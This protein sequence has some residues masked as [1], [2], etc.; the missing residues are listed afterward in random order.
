MSFDIQISK[1]ILALVAATVLV[2][3]DTAEAQY[4]G[5]NKVQYEDFDFQI[6]ETDHFD[7]YFYE[8]AE[9]AA[10]MV[11]QMAERWYARLSRLLDH[12]LRGHQPI[13]MYASHPHF[14]QTNAVGGQLSEST[15]GVTEVFKRRIVLPFAGPM[16]ETDHVL[17]H[18]IVHAFQFDIT[19]SGQIGINSGIPGALGMPLWFIEGMAEYLSVG[20]VDPHTSMWIRDALAND[21]MPT[22]EQLANPRYFPYRYGQALWSFIAGWYGDE[23]VGRMLKASRTSRDAYQAMYKVIGNGVNTLT[24]RWHASIEEAY[25]D[26]PDLTA[27]PDDYART[28]L[29]GELGT[30]NLN[31]AP[32]ISPDGS[33]IV[34]MSEKDL[35][36]IE[37]FLATTDSGT[38][39][40]KLT[41]TAF[42]SH[43]ESLQFINSAG[44][45]SPDNRHF[46]LGTVAEGR[47]KLT[48][49][50]TE[51]AEVVQDIQLDSLGEI[52]NPS[53]SADGDRIVFSAI[54]G[55]LSDLFVYDLGAEQLQRLTH[56][57]F[58]DLQPA[59]SPD[60]SQIVFVTDR[61]GADRD[62]LRFGDYRLAMLDPS[63]GF[64]TSLPSFDQ[65][66]N[67]NPQFSPDGASIFFISDR[68]GISNIYRLDIAQREI[69]QVTNV[70]TGVSGITALSPA[71][72]VASETGE[73][74]FALY[75][76][77]AYD[78]YMI[79]SEPPLAG[80]PPHTEFGLDRMAVLPPLDRITD[81][82]IAVLSDAETGLADQSSFNEEPY[83][84]RL[85]LDYVA[86]PYLVA[87]SD[88]FGTFFGGGA[89]LFWSDMLGE[90]NLATSLQ[91]NGSL[92][93]IAATVAYEN[94]RRRWNWGTA[95]SQI[96][97]LTG[98]LSSF[99]AFDSSL[100]QTVVQEELQRFRQTS[101][102]VVGFTSYAF[103]R[104][105][106]LEV[107]VGYRNIE[108]GWELQRRTRDFFTGQEVR[109]RVD[110][111]L[112]SL[113]VDEG[114]ARRY[115]IDPDLFGQIH[116]ASASAALV[117]DNSVFGLTGPMV[118]QRYRVQVSPLLG[119]LN[120]ANV[121][122]DY[123]KYVMPV[124]PFTIAGRLLHFG[125]YGPDADDSRLRDSYLGYPSLLRGYDFNSFDSNDCNFNTGACPALDRLFGSRLAVANLELRVPLLSLFGAGNGFY[126]FL[127]ID[128]IVFGDAGLA[129]NSNLAPRECILLR[130]TGSDCTADDT[131][132][133]QAFFLGG[134]RE[135][136]YS[137][138]AGLRINA[139]GFA[140]LEFDRVR[141]F[142]RDRWLWQFSFTPGF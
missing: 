72:S 93:D 123:R 98:T 70:L 97:Y 73:I 137:A 67:I 87:G 126:G 124:R 64:I 75:Q 44:A 29:A 128:F 40:R 102:E 68:D 139:F 106:R 74:A 14:E 55:G 138:G 9:D 101:R 99:I 27:A 20:P 33:R 34:F 41:R 109:D 76:N 111:D 36:S 91:V 48:I 5:R 95:V 35:F 49:I 130:Q 122:V 121:V 94:R 52:F 82:V 125:R 8:E 60:G 116:L 19:G 39:L 112:E 3:L 119:T 135:P 13:I 51:T 117:Y 86:Q 21:R 80:V 57:V 46:V 1:P 118:G 90:R 114:L 133:E 26:A 22:V 43:F 7:I 77:G 30:G 56:D 50:D 103:N 83:S 10:A 17:G 66:K 108:F 47:P 38:I 18:E 54:V 129:W 37:L 25:A 78:V 65:G 61:F 104:S 15:G 110:I 100:G 4:F 84:P 81:D 115:G 88:R 42:D 141:A 32:A 134:D 113:R 45:W 6:L 11:A 107:S 62:E 140:I 71:L 79:E 89:A 92:R 59:W 16:R 127:P 120:F 105:R 142:T 23:V 28:I 31:I 132:N 131:I 53:W 136:L 24:E 63:T 12:E 85:G 2:P 69:Y 58:A 96:P